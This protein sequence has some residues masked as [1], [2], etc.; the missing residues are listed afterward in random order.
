VTCQLDKK[1]ETGEDWLAKLEGMV[2]QSDP[3]KDQ[4]VQNF[5]ALY[6]KPLLEAE[7]A[8]RK[9]AGL[10]QT[11]MEIKRILIKFRPKGQDP[12]VEFNDE[13]GLEA[14]VRATPESSFNRPGEPVYLSQIKE[15]LKINPPKIDGAD[16]PYMYIHY[17][18]TGYL[19]I[20]NLTTT[21][22]IND[23]SDSSLTTNQALTAIHQ[24]MLHEEVTRQAAN[25]EA[26]R[27]IGLWPVPSLILY[28]LNK[29]IERVN[30]D[31]Y[32]GARDLL[33]SHCTDE[34]IESQS[35]NWSNVEAFAKRSDLIKD[36]L[37]AHKARKYRLSIHALLPH[38]EGIITDWTFLQSGGAIPFRQESKTKRFRDLLLSV[39]STNTFN[40]IVES[41][42]DFIV[43]GPVLSSFEDWS[44]KIDDTFAN[45]HVVE[46][47]KYE[48]SVF[49][50][51]NSIKLFLLLD[52]IHTL[53]AKS[54][55]FKKTGS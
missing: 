7:F 54:S 34:F 51:E 42:V 10:P 28:P 29:I 6:I 24:F 3:L 8:K 12:V 14:V 44:M 50:K 36:A 13:I 25:L 5:I 35:S 19:I 38:I 49:T 39:P 41:T 15:I 4:L 21:E 20:N 33:V 18:G 48:D 52:T 37:D 53:M 55:T 22:G 2:F 27:K 9:A 17:M 16:V 43:E 26:L 45:R 47:G 11:D 32:N 46:H 23:K 1:R 31:D 40:T 30:N